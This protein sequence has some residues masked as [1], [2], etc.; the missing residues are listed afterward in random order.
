MGVANLG[1][2]NSTIAIV[3]HSGDSDAVM[4]A[5]VAITLIALARGLIRLAGRVLSQEHDG[6]PAPDR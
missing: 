2:M 1:G 3:M 6:P 4:A 5:L